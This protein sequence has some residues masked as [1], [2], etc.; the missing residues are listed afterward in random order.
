MLHD[1]YNKAFGICQGISLSLS[2]SLSLS[3]KQKKKPLQS[4]IQHASPKTKQYV[5][6]ERQLF[7]VSREKDFYIF[8]C[9]EIEVN[10]SQ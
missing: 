3:P 2:L 9:G 10:A 1:L 7:S 5:N 6:V 8:N 4:T